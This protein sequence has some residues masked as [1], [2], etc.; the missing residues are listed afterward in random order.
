MGQVGGAIQFIDSPLSNDAD[1][2]ILG[3]RLGGGGGLINVW[4]SLAT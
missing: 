2:G 4:G 1:P 3:P